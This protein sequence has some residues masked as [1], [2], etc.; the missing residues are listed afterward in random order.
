LQFQRYFRIISKCLNFFKMKVLQAISFYL[1]YGFIWLFTWLPLSIQYLFSDAIFFL[2]FHVFHY[3]KKV[4]FKNLTMSF[5]EKSH[6]EIRRI[7]R[8][9]YRHL[10]DSFIES[11]AL[12]H[13]RKSDLDNRYQYKNTELINDLYS[14]GKSI[15]LVMGHYG[16]WDWCANLTNVSNHK[17]LAIYKVLHNKY[18]DKLI[19]D[20]RESHGVETI[21]ME[22][23]L[24]SLLDYKKKNIPTFTMFLAD[25]RPRMKNIQYWTTFLNQ[26]TPVLLG[27]EKIS[28]KLDMA[29]VFFHVR[30]IK[31]GY[32]ENEFKLVTDNASEEIEFAITEKHVRY[33]EALIA[34]EPAHWLWSHKRWKHKKS[35]YEK[36]H[37]NRVKSA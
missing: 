10:G 31:R 35:E 5:P 28:K 15:I 37:K 30:K 6:Q 20:L 21:P 8:R 11:F 33:L 23:T 32:Y 16:N 17:I 14:R 7:A 1:F 18:F 9:F 26:D 22:S 13:M 27:P 29:V 2:T 12:M 36:L 19:K 25:Q 34:E 4:V 24:R 3:R